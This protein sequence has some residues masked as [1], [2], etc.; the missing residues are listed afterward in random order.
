MDRLGDIDQRGNGTFLTAK[1]I[2]D[3]PKIMQRSWERSEEKRRRYYEELTPYLDRLGSEDYEGV[4]AA[5]KAVSSRYFDPLHPDDAKWCR[6]ILV[7]RGF[8]E[9]K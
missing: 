8:E 1:M 6:E 5:A 7:S 3:F 9:F 4:L 2:R